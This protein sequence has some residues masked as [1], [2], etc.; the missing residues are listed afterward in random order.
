MR[1][2][3]LC[4]STHRSMWKHDWEQDV[5]QRAWPELARNYSSRAK[6]AVVFADGSSWTIACRSAPRVT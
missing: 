2:Y 1:L 3:G 6:A 5:S 4:P